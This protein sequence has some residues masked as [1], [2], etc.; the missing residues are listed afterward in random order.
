MK[1]K[2]MVLNFLINYPG[3]FTV[4]DIAAALDRPANTNLRTALALLVAEGKVV[5]QPVFSDNYRLA[6]GYTLAENAPKMF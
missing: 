2:A 5:R 3:L 6:F 4:T 1:L